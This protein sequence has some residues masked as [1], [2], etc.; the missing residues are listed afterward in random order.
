M[1]DAGVLRAYGA[2]VVVCL[3]C[4]TAPVQPMIAARLPVLVLGLPFPLLWNVGWLVASFTALAA[5]QWRLGEH[6]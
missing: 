6:S 5:L 3:A 4:L 2:F 1:T